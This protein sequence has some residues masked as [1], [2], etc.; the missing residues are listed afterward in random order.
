MAKIEETPL[1]FLAVS[2]RQLRARW[3]SSPKRRP[4]LRI[5]DLSNGRTLLRGGFREIDGGGTGGY[6]SVGLIGSEIRTL[7]R[8]KAAEMRARRFFFFRSFISYRVYLQARLQVSGEWLCI[9][10][11]S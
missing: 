6:F 10:I 8:P 11:H 5:R 9:A 7:R 2:L 3:R 1:T 4:K